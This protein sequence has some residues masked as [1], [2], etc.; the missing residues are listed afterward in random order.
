MTCETICPSRDRIIDEPRGFIRTFTDQ[1]Y[2]LSPAYN[3]QWTIVLSPD[4]FVKLVF[5][6]MWI[7]PEHSI[8]VYLRALNQ[9]QIDK[10]QYVAVTSP[11]WLFSDTNKIIVSYE[12]GI[13]H[14]S[15]GFAAAY[16]QSA[17]TFRYLYYSWRMN[18]WMFKWMKTFASSSYIKSTINCWNMTNWFITPVLYVD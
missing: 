2:I 12:T 15:A 16:S 18:L 17:G 8:N 1:P 14:Q 6:K 5:L 11:I 13:I 10:T 3:C 4:K 9:S 7:E